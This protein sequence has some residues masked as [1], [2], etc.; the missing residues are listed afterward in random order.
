[1]QTLREFL[2]DKARE[3]DQRERLQRREEWLT[4]VN[5]L[6]RQLRAWLEAVDSEK[7]LMIYDQ[8]YD[9]LEQGLGMYKVSGLNVGLRDSLVKIIPVSRNVVA[10]VESKGDAGVRAEGRVDISDGLRKYILYR[11]LR[12]G[13]DR[14]YALDEQYKATLLDQ[15]RF[16]EIMQDLLS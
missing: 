14:W 8:E 10:S 9:K 5:H 13:R 1:M 7:L 6:I 2:R 11:T 4:A 16:E 3:D 12:D 15:A